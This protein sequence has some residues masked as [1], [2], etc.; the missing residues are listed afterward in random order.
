MVNFQTI[1]EGKRRYMTRN[2][3]HKLIVDALAANKVQ[4]ERNRRRR[5]NGHMPDE[6]P[7]STPLHIGS[8]E[9]DFDDIARAIVKRKKET[10]VER[11][12]EKGGHMLVNKTPMKKESVIKRATMK[13]KPVKGPGPPI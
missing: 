10:E 6:E 4:T 5:R 3:S 8:S 1:G 7:T 11:V 9:I 2:E 12:K 13:L